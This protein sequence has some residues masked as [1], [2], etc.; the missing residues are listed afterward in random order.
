MDQGRPTLKVYDER[1]QQYFER[2]KDKDMAGQ[3]E[4]F[5][6]RC[7]G[8]EILDLGCGPALASAYFNSRGFSV[9]AVDGSEK[10]LEIARKNAPVSEFRNVDYSEDFD[11]GR[12][13]DGIWASASLLH[14]NR[15]TFEK[16]FSS[17]RAHA[18]PR[19]AVYFS[20]KVLDF[21]PHED[22]RFF[23]FWTPE[24]LKPILDKFRF[25]TVEQKIQDSSRARWIE[26]IGFFSL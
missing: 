1:A 22:E 5:L 10:M 17:L 20:L 18:R 23:Q 25:V 14:L 8:R 19:A 9:L 6:S 12:K 21:I 2:N 4:A 3:Y 7:K 13:F 15:E 16:T 24:E 11:L 26:T